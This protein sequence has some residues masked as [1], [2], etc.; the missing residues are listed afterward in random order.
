MQFRAVIAYI[1]LV[2]LCACAPEF[3]WRELNSSEGGFSALMP[4]KP[5]SEE[6]ALAGAPGVMMHLWSA[7]AAGC[8]FGVSYADYP[9]EGRHLLDD[10]RDALVANI[11]GRLLD[12][13]PIASNGL[14]GFEFTAESED[15]LLQARLLPSGPRLFQLVVLGPKKDVRNAAAEVDLFMS[16][17]RL[18]AMKQAPAGHLR[19]NDGV[20]TTNSVNS[21][22]RPSS[23]ATVHTQV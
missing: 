5:R 4:A 6:R 12:E 17:F 18:P 14:T 20:K 21:S 19:Q 7:H 8:V 15:R 23:I 3:D 11:R 9:A 1:A 13:K 22:S 16:S 2:A 10:T